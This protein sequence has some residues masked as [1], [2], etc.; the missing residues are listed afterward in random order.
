MYKRHKTAVSTV[1]VLTAVLCYSTKILY[2]NIADIAI[3]V[4]SISVAVYIATMS[5]LLG[6]PYADKLKSIR[7]TEIKE[8]SQLG[9]LTTYLRVA[10]NCGILTILVSSLY[11]IPSI[12]NVSPQL[13]RLTSSISCA[14]FVINIFFLWLVFKFLATAL[15]NSASNNS[16]VR[17]G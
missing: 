14:I 12:A 2:D 11:K 13:Q 4:V 10:G 3:T 17:S 7:D 5:A 1:F 8:K 9:V 16:S 6:S 15:M